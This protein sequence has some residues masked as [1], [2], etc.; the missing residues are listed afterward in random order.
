MGNARGL[1]KHEKEL[2]DNYTLMQ[3]FEWY[4]EA[5]GKYWNLMKDRAQSLGEMGI[6]AIWLPPP[7]K[8]SGPEDNGYGTYD[9]WDLGEFEEK[10]T[11]G[12]KWGTKEE[13]LQ[14]VKA[15]KENGVVSYVDAVL[16]HKMGA[17]GLETF[18][19]QMVAEDDR[20]KDVGEPVDIEGWTKY[21]FPARNGKYSD[22][23]WNFNHFTGVDYDNKSQTTAIY[24]ILGDNK[25]WALAVDGENKNYDYLM[26]CDIDHAH[27]DARADIIKWGEWVIKESGCD[28]FRFDAIKHIDE[29]FISEFVQQ[30]REKVGNSD[31]FCV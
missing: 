31:L 23:K 7:T 11:R 26:G 5:G 14:C 25:G 10:G 12:T 22:F 15:L 21:D 29:F 17:D 6:T 13:Y 18:K 9:L 16:N 28:G 27:P 8:G 30:V 2:Q 20:T 1:N 24:R 4:Q 3:G 19:A